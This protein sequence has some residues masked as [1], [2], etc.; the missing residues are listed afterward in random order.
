MGSNTEYHLRAT[1]I[2]LVLFAVLAG[3]AAWHG[4]SAQAHILAGGSAHVGAVALDGA[5]P[6]PDNCAIADSWCAY[7]TANA[8]A[9]LCKQLPPVHASGSGVSTAKV[10]T[11]NSPLLG[12]VDGSPT[13][14]GYT[15]EL[16]LV[17]VASNSTMAAGPGLAASGQ[18]CT[19]LMGGMWMPMTATSA[20]LC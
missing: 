9:E 18:W 1:A 19:A 11:S 4:P 17:P 14:A 12:I 7:C 3:I 10:D 16:P 8:D 13:I 20:A 2:A 6:P 15:G 5:A